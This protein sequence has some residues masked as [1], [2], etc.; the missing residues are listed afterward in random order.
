MF[1]CASPVAGLADRCRGSVVDMT[2]DDIDPS[3][4]PLEE[5]LD[6]LAQAHGAPGG[7]AASGVMTAISAA[8]LGMVAG[9]TADD[10]EARGAGQRLRSIRRAATEAAEEDGVRSAAFGAALGMDEGPQREQAVRQAT[11]EAIASSLAIGRIGAP[12]VEEAR[13]LSRIGNP[14]VKADL[15]VAVEALRGGLEGASV[16][17]RSN[18]D[19]LARHRSP[20]DGLD[21]QVAGFEHDIG[22]LAQKRAECDRIAADCRAG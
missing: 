2:G 11:V 6:R 8:L 9:Y 7:G 15:R 22:D 5:W 16:T 14:H 12:L 19:L 4:T 17:A 10:S 3:E 20:D 13:L 18:L 21:A 1:V